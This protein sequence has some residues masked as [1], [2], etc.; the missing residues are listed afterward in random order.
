MSKTM[1]LIGFGVVAALIYFLVVFIK[2]NGVFELFA[3]TFAGLSILLLGIL[4][5]R[6]MAGGRANG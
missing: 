3:F 6:V 5:I 1:I 2:K 4:G